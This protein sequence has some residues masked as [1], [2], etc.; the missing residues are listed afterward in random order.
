MGTLTKVTDACA[1]PLA[2][3]SPPVRYRQGKLFL[4]FRRPPCM[5][6]CSEHHLPYDR[7]TAMARTVASPAGDVKPLFS[8]GRRPIRCPD[9]PRATP[10]FWGL[11]APPRTAG[12]ITACG[13]RKWLQRP[14]QKRCLSSAAT[15]RAAEARTSARRISDPRRID[16]SPA[17]A[18]RP[19]TGRARRRHH[20]LDR[21][22]TR[23][24]R[25]SGPL[26]LCKKSH[27]RDRRRAKKTRRGGFPAPFGSPPRIPPLLPDPRPADGRR[28]RSRSRRGA[29]GL[30]SR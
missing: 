21:N 3:P 6:R 24:K 18:S 12:E 4:Q 8:S 20:P 19:R 1:P 9:L 7:I 29:Q 30:R 25:P 15:G 11:T 5:N 23:Q 13:A 22:T 17:A 2:A 28:A 16:Q 27:T 14:Y 26:H 10:I